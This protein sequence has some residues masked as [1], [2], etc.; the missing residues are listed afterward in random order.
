[1]A[2]AGGG[3]RLTPQVLP[4]VRGGPRLAAD[5]SADLPTASHSTAGCL[6]RGTPLLA[7]ESQEWALQD[8][9][10]GPTGYE[11]AALTN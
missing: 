1:M 2:R 3:A 7:N 6:C 10:L 4:F 8:S 11:P 9:N 5:G